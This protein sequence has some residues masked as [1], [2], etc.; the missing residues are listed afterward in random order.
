MF[1]FFSFSAFAI[2][3]VSKY[4]RKQ[5]TLW[6]TYG[7]GISLLSI[8]FGY[9]MADSYPSFAQITIFISLIVYLFMYGMTYAPLMWIWVA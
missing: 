9:F 1:L 5:M 2:E 7:I 3:Y 8:T 4:G 6:G